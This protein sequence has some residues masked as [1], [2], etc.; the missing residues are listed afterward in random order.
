MPFYSYLEY[1]R[2]CNLTVPSGWSQLAID[3]PNPQAIRVQAHNPYFQCFK[4]L[5][6]LRSLYGILQIKAIHTLT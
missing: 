5:A 3:I 6:K 4:V 2:F 1:R